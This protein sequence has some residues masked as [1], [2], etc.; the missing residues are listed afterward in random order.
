MVAP[1][2][3]KALT[4]FAPGAQ[5]ATSS[6]AEVEV[7]ISSPERSGSNG[8]VASM[9][10]FPVRSPAEERMVLVTG[11]G[12]ASRTTSLTATAWVV[13]AALE[14]GPAFATSCFISGESGV[15]ELNTTV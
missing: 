4:T 8:L 10:I 2:L 5:V 7:P 14:A 13:L 1:M 3:L 15:L 12:V 11:Q 9:R 6:P